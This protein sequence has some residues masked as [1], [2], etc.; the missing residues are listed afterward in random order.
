MSAD[1]DAG[2]TPPDFVAHVVVVHTVTYWVAGLVF[3]VVFDYQA[4]F[5]TPPFATYMRPMDSMVVVAGPLF[6]PVRGAIMGI[7]LWPFRRVLLERERGWL[8]LWGLFVGVAILNA[9]APAPGAFE[10]LVY[11]TVPLTLHLWGL[12]EV[13]VQTLLFAV[14]LVY[15]ERNPGD[16][17][18]GA[19][20]IGLFVV[21]LCLSL[22]AVLLEAGAFG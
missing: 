4:L 5:S 1:D 20:F 7:A 18:L 15:W 9:P 22:F 10:G 12:P 13:L 8:A 2:S 19:A 17:R 21:L 6:Q 11:T 16:R 14:G 3:S